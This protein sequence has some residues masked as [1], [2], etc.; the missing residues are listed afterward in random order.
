MKH[1][2]LCSFPL[3]V[4]GYFFGEQK[5]IHPFVKASHKMIFCVY[6][7]YVNVGI[8]LAALKHPHSRTTI[9][10][11]VAERTDYNSFFFSIAM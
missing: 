8:V 6:I 3:Q 1:F 4:L 7:A 10:L 5:L 2:R 9:K 11:R